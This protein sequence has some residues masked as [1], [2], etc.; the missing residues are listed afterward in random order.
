[1]KSPEKSPPTNITEIEPFTPAEVLK[2]IK[3]LQKH[4]APGK[5]DITSDI[6]LL[7]G[8]QTIAKLT[9][10][11]NIILRTK[12]IPKTWE[13]AKVIILY[14]KG[15]RRDIKNYRPISL[16]AHSYKIFTRLLESRIEVQLD[17]NQPREQAG[18]RRAYS[19]RDHLQALNQVIEKCNEHNMTL[20]IGFIDYEKAFDSVEHFAI[21]D[22]LRKMQI[23]ETYITI[24][25]NIYKNAS[26]RIHLDNHVSEPFPIERGVR[27]GDPIS[28][29]L[30]TAAMEIVFQRAELAGGIDIQGEE[31]KDLRF[32]DDVAPCTKEEKSMSKQLN[33]LN[34]ESKKIGLKIHK[35][36]TKYM[37]NFECK[38]EIKIEE[39]IIEEVEEY[40]YLGQTIN[41]NQGIETEVKSRIRAA[42]QC[43]GKYRE[44]FL[45]DTL[46]MTLKRKTFNQCVLPTLTYG[47]ETWALTKT[48]ELKI[49]STQRAMERKML[50]LKLLDKVRH[51]NIREKT[52]V[53]DLQM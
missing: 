31:L 22:A 11:Y 28:P 36:K 33:Q 41:P 53:T 18:F 12:E 48:L 37:S 39:D 46:P 6:I 40:K 25:E 19:T 26:A 47:C 27:Q 14:K 35:G 32:A 9:D 45:D 20:C 21:F 23:N 8:Q 52:N 49:R 29:K 38:S 2:I 4:K 3:K 15:D 42:W 17:A 5:D 1:M 24:L 13:E 51:T 7:A 30:F 16:L 44:I 50:N 43:F 10:A 34:T